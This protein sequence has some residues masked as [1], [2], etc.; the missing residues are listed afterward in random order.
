MRE[1]ESRSFVPP[2]GFLVSK[3]LTLSPAWVFRAP[4]DI[5]AIASRSREERLYSRTR[6]TSTGELNCSTRAGKRAACRAALCKRAPSPIVRSQVVWGSST[7]TPTS[8]WS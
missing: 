1:S 2:A 5:E 7:L 8:S 4:G 3:D 6:A